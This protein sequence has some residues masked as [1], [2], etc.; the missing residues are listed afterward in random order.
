MFIGT[1]AGSLLGGRGV[2][3]GSGWSD[4]PREPKGIRG[5]TDSGNG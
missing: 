5:D 4:K 2:V 1:V 3:D